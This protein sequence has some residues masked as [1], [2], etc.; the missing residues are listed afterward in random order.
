M[1]ISKKYVETLQMGY[2]AIIWTER[3]AARIKMYSK[4]IG[5]TGYRTKGNKLRY[6]L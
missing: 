2:W 1:K 3:S 6:R 5:I 4:F